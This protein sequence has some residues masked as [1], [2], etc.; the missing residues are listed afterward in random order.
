[1]TDEEEHQ[2][3]VNNFCRIKNEYHNLKTHMMRLGHRVNV[4][5]MAQLQIINHNLPELAEMG[6]IYLKL[7]YNKFDEDFK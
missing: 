4:Q 1:M 2:Y 6:R 5:R 3:W 7:G